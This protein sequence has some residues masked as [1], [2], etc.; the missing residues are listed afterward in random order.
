MVEN[1]SG[2]TVVERSG[3]FK[4]SVC[5][6]ENAELSIVVIGG[7]HR[8][9]ALKSLGAG[10]DLGCEDPDLMRHLAAMYLRGRSHNGYYPMRIIS[11]P[12]EISGLVEWA[13]LDNMKNNVSRFD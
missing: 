10:F 1:D 6:F 7:N 4:R 12:P 5:E 9:K 13:S 3:V 8:V 2:V 11:C